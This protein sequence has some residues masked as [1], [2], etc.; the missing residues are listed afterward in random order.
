MNFEIIKAQWDELA[1]WKKLLLIILLSIGIGYLVYMFVLSDKIKERDNLKD[2]IESLKTQLQSV[3]RNA[4]PE[5]RAQ[6]QQELEK[7]KEKTELL[8]AQLEELKSKF[9]P[10]DDPQ[11]TLVFITK[12]V[13][14]NNLVLNNFVINNI[15]DVY[16]KYNPSTQKIEYITNESGNG[17]PKVSSL[18]PKKPNSEG[19]NGNNKPEEN[20]NE[21]DSMPKV[22]L[23][24]VSVS[25]N[26]IGSPS[27][28]IN[29]IKNVSYTKNYVRIERVYLKKGSKTD[30]LDANIE[31]SSFFSP[32]M[33]ENKAE[34]KKKEGKDYCKMKEV[35]YKCNNMAKSQKITKDFNKCS[36]LSE[37]FVKNAEF[38]KD[39][40]VEYK[41]SINSACFA[42]CIEDKDFIK[43]LQ[44]RCK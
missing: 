2:E 7:E 23:K 16:L 1:V 40:K 6:L 38:L 5:R 11:S 26:V 33:N 9:L 8:N 31:L 25:I 19:E 36:N 42:G 27:D 41:K 12:Q 4:T 17:L 29:F 10:K 35:Y 37:D 15:T 30:I 34:N 13:K 22:H 3:M 28:I 43:N 24:K 39:K 14:R 20:N 18:V 21:E 44:K 32:E